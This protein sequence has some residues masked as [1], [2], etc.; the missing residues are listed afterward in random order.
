MAQTWRS[1][2]T[3]PDARRTRPLDPAGLERIALR[4]V[5]RYATTR[6]KLAGYLGRKLR[7]RGWSGEGTAEVDALVSRFA[8][9]GYV[10]DAAF[11]SARAAG[12]TRRGYGLRRVSATLKA[13][14]IDADD[15]APAEAATREQAWEAALVFA[16]RRKIG[17]FAPAVPDRAAREKAFAALLRAGHDVAVARRIV[18][19][20]PGDVPEMDLG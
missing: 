2:P 20:G 6:A 12:L 13:A 19:C 18:Q 8:E 4:Y 17:P 5:E 14:G 10:D 11:A 9:L 16:R 1:R 7:E 15:A 3:D